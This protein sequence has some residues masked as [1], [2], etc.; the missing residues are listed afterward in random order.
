MR[1][2]CKFQFGGPSELKAGLSFW[3]LPGGAN[4]WPLVAE[5][6]F[7]YDADEGAAGDGRLEE[8]PAATAGGANRL[9]AA[10]HGQ[11][12]WF[13]PNVTTKTAFALEVL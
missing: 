2:L 12:G 8:Y 3:Y 7:D 11:S 6:S 5:F 13:N 9:F 1:D 4:S 10:L